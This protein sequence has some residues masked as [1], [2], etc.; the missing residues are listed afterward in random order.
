MTKH[1]VSEVYMGHI[2][3]YSTA[4]LGGVKY[5]LSG[6]GGAGLHDRYGPAG[7]VHHYIICDVSPDGNVNQQVVRFFRIDE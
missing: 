3:A 7:N 2:H 6:G 4:V 1:R 5:T